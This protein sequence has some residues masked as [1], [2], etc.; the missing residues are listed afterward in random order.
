MTQNEE[1]TQARE[2]ILDY[3]IL[4][5]EYPA[6]FTD[7]Q[8][9]TKAEGKLIKRV[10]SDLSEENSIHYTLNRKRPEIKKAVEEHI[11]K[12]TINLR[13]RHLEGA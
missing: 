3:M 2:K 7:I 4:H 9:A 12:V 10:L 1:Y 6:S 8:Q 11:R 13:Q 5:R